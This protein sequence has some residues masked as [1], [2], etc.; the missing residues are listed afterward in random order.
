MYLFNFSIFLTWLCLVRM[1][2]TEIRKRSKM[3]IAHLK[4]IN[5][6]TG[7]KKVVNWWT[8]WNSKFPL[9]IW[10][11]AKRILNAKFIGFWWYT[12]WIPPDQ[13]YHKSIDDFNIFFLIAK[14]P[15][16]VC[17]YLFFGWLLRINNNSNRFS[18]KASEGSNY[19][20]KRFTCER[21]SAE[22]KHLCYDFELL[23]V[24]ENLS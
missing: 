2:E 24:S 10:M 3:Q 9:V 11:R 8:S 21:R 15:Q 20:L 14:Y 7:Q 22:K 23:F 4:A 16:I 19:F 5:K 18:I 1:R 6:W 13:W 17:V 12:R